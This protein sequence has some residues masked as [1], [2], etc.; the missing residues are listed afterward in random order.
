MCELFLWPTAHHPSDHAQP[1]GDQPWDCNRWQWEVIALGLTATAQATTNDWIAANGKWESATNWS[2]GTAPS[3]SDSADRIIN[4]GSHTVTIDGITTNTPSTLTISNFIVG[5]FNTLSLFFAG[6][7]TPLVV[8]N[9]FSISSFGASVVISNS[10]LRVDGVSGGGFAV[11]GSLTLNGG[12]IIVTNPQA[13]I[14]NTGTG[15]MTILSGTVLATRVALAASG[16]SRGTLTMNGGTLISTNLLIGVSSN[17]LGAVKVAGGGSLYVTNAA[18]NAVTEARYGSLVLTGGVFTT[19]SLLITNPSGSFVN[20][21]GT[22]TITGQAQVDQGTQTVASGITQVSSNF[23]VGSTANS[24][25]TVNVTGGTLVVTNGVF[26]VGNSGTLTNGSG[27]GR[28]TVSN[29]TLVASTILLG[30]S[31][32]G[33][34]DLT[35]ANGGLVQSAGTN[36]VLVCNDFGQLG[37]NLAWSSGT[38]YCGYVHPGAYTLAN[39]TASCQDM[40]VGYDNA[41]TMTIAGGAMDISSRLTIG[42]LGSPVVATGTVSITG[43]QVT[44]NGDS[45]IGNDGVGQLSISGG[46]VMAATKVIV[47]NGSNPGILTVAAGGAMTALSSLTIGDCGA[48]HVGVVTITG[49]NLFVTNAA[50]NA[51]LD[52]RNGTLTLNSGLLQVD[53]FVMTNSCASF[54]HSGGLLQ[55]NQAVLDPARDA[56]GDGIPNGWEQSHGL[57]PLNA[58]DAGADNDG[59]GLSNLREYQLGT[60]P[61]DASSP[62]RITAIAREGNNVRV[63]WTTV[64]GT[65]N[66]VQ[67][68]PGVAGGNYTNNFSDL[69]AQL[70]IL[71]STVTSTNYLD[72][73]GATNSPSRYYRIRSYRNE[74][75]L[76]FALGGEVPGGGFFILG[77]DWWVFFGFNKGVA[78]GEEL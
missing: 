54:V 13:I 30:S 19:D 72:L 32:G 11:D 77:G 12:S 58:A 5:G 46:A 61:S 68:S 62:Y 22:F 21:G 76:F 48:G 41:G 18:H 57:D 43:G 52:V 56:D 74:W 28:V 73:N 34:G 35:L 51:T 10:A 70:F 6:T 39:G 71:G 47:G 9:D 42:Y 8:R 26:G 38:M 20:N 59:D 3:I 67:V 78:V 4:G 49:G 2:L 16:F 17:G 44:V 1:E 63:T 25:G 14:G 64:G 27:V 55:Y 60:D 31:A 24:T 15:S 29:G 7:S 50:H 75:V 65:T 33:Q 36:P 69:S 37:G 66:V 23:F 53:R 40:Y 45:Y